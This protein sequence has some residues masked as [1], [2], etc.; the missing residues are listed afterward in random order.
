MY[1]IGRDEVHN[2]TVNASV[3]SVVF[4]DLAS[5]ARYSA[6]VAAVNAIG[7]GAPASTSYLPPLGK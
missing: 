4:R 5:G 3:T 2:V 1:V 7:E 6:R